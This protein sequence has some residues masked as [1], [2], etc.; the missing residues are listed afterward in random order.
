M[1]GTPKAE[2]HL[3]AF[4]SQR[5]ATDIDVLEAAAG[6][7]VERR[8][9]LAG[10]LESPE[11]AQFEAERPTLGRGCVA[12]LTAVLAP[13]ETK[14]MLGV[15]RPSIEVLM[16]GARLCAEVVGYAQVAA[17]IRS[18]APWRLSVQPSPRRR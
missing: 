3:M 11:G 14:I 16:R 9:C 8:S 15:H 6:S 4:A 17:L 13:I 2:R 1:H 5:A 18:A 10:D 7:R 12:L